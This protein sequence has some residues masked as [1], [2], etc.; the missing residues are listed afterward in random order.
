M[1]NYGKKSDKDFVGRLY[2]NKTKKDGTPLKAPYLRGF[3][4]IDG[5]KHNL[6]GF[7]SD[8]TSSFG[9]AIDKNDKGGSKKIT[10]KTDDFP[11]A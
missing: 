8:K 6:V 11:F 5:V 2:I 9:M 10:K 1:S 3:V 4:E 7:Y